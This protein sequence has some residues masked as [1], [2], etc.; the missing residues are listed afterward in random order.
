MVNHLKKIDLTQIM[1]DED[2]TDLQGEVACQG[3][4]CEI[5]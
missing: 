2:E 3:H 1:E 4:S 5:T